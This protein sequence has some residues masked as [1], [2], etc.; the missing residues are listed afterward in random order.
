MHLLARLR[1]AQLHTRTDFLLHNITRH[2]QAL[3]QLGGK[4]GPPAIQQ[5]SYFGMVSL[6]S[7]ARRDSRPGRSKRLLAVFG[8]LGG[9]AFLRLSHEFAGIWQWIGGTYFPTQSDSPF[10]FSA[11]VRM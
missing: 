5:I 10:D 3:C 4:S 11:F 2:P 1:I 6:R 9:L 8:L 7:Q